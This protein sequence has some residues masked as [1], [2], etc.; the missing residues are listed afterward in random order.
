MQINGTTIESV[1]QF[2]CLGSMTND[3]NRYSGGNEDENK[4]SKTEIHGEK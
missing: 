1:R 3:D 2:W 4:C